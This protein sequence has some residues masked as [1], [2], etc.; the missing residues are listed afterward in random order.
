MTGRYTDLHLHLLPNVDDGPRS[1]EEVTKLAQGIVD[2]GVFQTAVTPHFNCWNPDLLSN[3]AELAD[4][5]ARLRAH[6]SEAGIPLEIFPGAEHFLTPEIVEQIGRNE[7]PLLGPGP[8]ILV[9]LPFNNRPLYA[10][11]VLYQIQLAGLRPVL[12]HPERYSWVQANP[13]AVGPM[14][15]S[16]IVLQ[17]TA[18]SLS[19]HYGGRIKKTAERLL[20]SGAYQLVGS[21]KHHPQQSR[22][23]SDM[24]SNVR[25]LTDDNVANLLFEENPRRVLR[26]EPV[27]PVPAVERPA[28]K[29]GL[30]GLFRDQ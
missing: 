14:L 1:W 19:G 26:G 15:S 18:A 7:A 20:E 16:E 22:D 21:D 10:E 11:D 27:L 13:D 6:L 4:H 28:G 25:A 5:M 29:K 12:A 17:L 30:F 8:Y 3:R 9:E 23:L 24:E 2:D